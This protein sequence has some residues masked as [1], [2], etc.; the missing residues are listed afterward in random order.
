MQLFPPPLFSAFYDH[1]GILPVAKVLELVHSAFPVAYWRC[2][3]L[4]RLLCAP[5]H[6]KMCAV[7]VLRTVSRLSTR[8]LQQWM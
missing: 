5:W 8:Y 1:L 3:F 7:A 2:S 6:A 4:L